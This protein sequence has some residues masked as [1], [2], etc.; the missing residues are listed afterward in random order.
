MRLEHEF[1]A[2][3]RADKNLGFDPELR[4]R[5]NHDRLGIHVTFVAA[6]RCSVFGRYRNTERS[7]LRP[8]PGSLQAAAY[9][10]E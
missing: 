4:E 6:V 2:F 9:H 7:D 1:A 10:P 8:L 3:E 5:V